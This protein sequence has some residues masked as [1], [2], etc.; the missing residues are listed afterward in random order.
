MPIPLDRALAIFSQGVKQLQVSR[1]ITAANEAV[2]SIRDSEEKDAEKTQRIRS[3]ANQLTSS[4][5]G[6]TSAQ[7]AQLAGQSLIPSKLAA[8]TNPFQAIVSGTE[9]QKA[10]AQEFLSNQEKRKQAAQ[11][12]SE[13]RIRARQELSF[14]R[15]ET[16]RSER[17]QRQARRLLDREQRGREATLKASE[18][19]Q[20]RKLGRERRARFNKTQ[21]AFNKD[22]KELNKAARSAKTIVTLVNSNSPLTRGAVGFLV[23][24]MLGEVGNLTQAEREIATQSKDLLNRVN[25]ALK[26]N[27]VSQLTDKDK[28][29]LKNLAVKFSGV[30]QQS[31]QQI[32]E[33]NTNQLLSGE[34]FSE[35]DPNELIKRVTGNTVQGFS[36]DSAFGSKVPALAP[37]GNTI[38]PPNTAN[39][40]KNR[41]KHLKP[42]GGN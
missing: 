16:E 21:I 4:L 17:E 27:L 22:I 33:R 25:D 12:G 30:Q 2:Q 40:T 41:R 5:I 37:I 18:V 39:S 6:S 35:K 29:A 15:A 34:L 10:K 38:A 42:L 24:R 1:S 36:S 14:N 23:P 13:A 32:A 8:P 26:K 11:E 31:I 7:E 28:K 19:S 9:E 20:E 3:I